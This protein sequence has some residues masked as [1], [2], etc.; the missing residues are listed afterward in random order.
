M[1]TAVPYDP[2]LWTS[3][4]SAEVSASASLTG[5]VFVAVSINLKQ[6]VGMRQ[7]VARAAKALLTLAV[8]LAISILCLVP[9]VTRGTLGAELAALSVAYWLLGVWLHTRTATTNRF[10]SQTA[11]RFQL[12]VTQLSTLPLVG[13]ALSL[14]GGHGG[15]LYWMVAGTLMSFFSALIDGWVLLIEILR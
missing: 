11:K 4:F 5:L 6:I 2:G 14:L 12:I 9:D 10:A 7:L 8:I 3:F 13:A 15:G 1:H